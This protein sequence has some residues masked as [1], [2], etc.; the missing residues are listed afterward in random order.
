M[1]K[2]KTRVGW[3]KALGKSFFHCRVGLSHGEGSGWISQEHNSPPT[4]RAMRGSFWDRHCENL[5]EFL[6][7]EPTKPLKTARG[8][9]RSHTIPQSPVIC[10]NYRLSLLTSLCL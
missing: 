7:L 4:A 5:L 3:D 9:S 8:V 2:W 6:D 1:Y 10:Q